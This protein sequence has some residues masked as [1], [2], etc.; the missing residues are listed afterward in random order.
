MWFAE[1]GVREF[2]LPSFMG[3]WDR[4][5][6]GG[7]KDTPNV[8]RSAFPPFFDSHRCGIL[9]PEQSMVNREQCGGAW[10]RHVLEALCGGH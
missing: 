5:E 4:N 9:G 10:I 1:E 8:G 7:N 2:V 6:K 3:S